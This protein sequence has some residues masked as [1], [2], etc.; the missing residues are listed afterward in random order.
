MYLEHVLSRPCRNILFES[1]D[2]LGL[3][4]HYF[5]TNE[6]RSV[7]TFDRLKVGSPDL[8]IA[9]LYQTDGSDIARHALAL[10]LLHLDVFR[11]YEFR[12]GW[13]ILDN[14]TFVLFKN[15]QLSLFEYAT[16]LCP[17]RP[18]YLFFEDLIGL[19][20]TWDRSRPSV[21]KLIIHALYAEVPKLI[22]DGRYV[23]GVGTCTNVDVVEVFDKIAHVDPTAYNQF[24][25]IW[26]YFLRFNF[27]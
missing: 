13:R 12:F 4:I 16:D 23:D 1:Y 5:L 2:N 24:K 9:E 15:R 27:S 17:E 8:I 3:Q 21:E 14:H 7:F 22:I 19:L 25:S 26:N 18:G 6:C 11:D 10:R 20:A